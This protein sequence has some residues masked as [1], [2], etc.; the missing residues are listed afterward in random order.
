MEKSVEYLNKVSKYFLI[1]KKKCNCSSFSFKSIIL[2]I[3]RFYLTVVKAI[4]Q[5][6]LINFNKTSQ[7]QIV[8]NTTILCFNTYTCLLI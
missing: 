4:R 6:V 2:M 8:Y 1:C 5:W 7:I 3:S